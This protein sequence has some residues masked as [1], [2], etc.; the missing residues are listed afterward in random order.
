MSAHTNG[1]REPTASMKISLD[2]WDRQVDG[3][4][5]DGSAGRSE[6][7]GSPMDD[8]DQDN[9]GLSAEE[10]AKRKEERLKRHRER[11]QVSEGRSLALLRALLPP[12]P[13]RDA[14]LTV[15]LFRNAS[16][17]TNWRP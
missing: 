14:H 9:D 8:G 6:G 15:A 16:P 12:S 2:A 1:G 11:K 4:L 3:E 17:A 10:L 7:S 5:A 13:P